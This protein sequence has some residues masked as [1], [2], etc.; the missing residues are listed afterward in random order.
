MTV[1]GRQGYRK[2]HATP[3]P[4]YIVVRQSLTQPLFDDAQPFS[5]HRP[6]NP[7]TAPLLAILSP[8]IAATAA[9]D[10]VDLR[11]SRCPLPVLIDQ[12]LACLSKPPQL[13]RCTALLRAPALQHTPVLIDQYLAC[14]S[15]PPQLW[16]CTA[17]L[18][19]PALK[20]LPRIDRSISRLPRQAPAAVLMDGHSLGRVAKGDPEAP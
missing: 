7:R 12:Y 10:K 6:F 18:R 5:G 9:G 16:R 15:K 14:L 13:W 20:H 19:A 1:P 3:L 2:D 4:G 8:R 17:L 11:D